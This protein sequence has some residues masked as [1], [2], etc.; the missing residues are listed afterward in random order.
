[1]DIQLVETGE[2]EV[3]EA[4][5]MENDGE[6]SK[7]VP[8]DAEVNEYTV[9]RPRRRVRRLL[10][11]PRRRRMRDGRHRHTGVLYFVVIGINFMP[12]RSRSI[13]TETRWTAR[14]ST[15]TAR[16]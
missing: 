4:Q 16:T 11:V 14:P 10:D 13:S 7:T 2:D 5:T 6:V 8:G 1:M 3:L 9:M 12:G 15:T